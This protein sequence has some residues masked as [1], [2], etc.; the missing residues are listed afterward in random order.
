[1]YNQGHGAIFGTGE[2][3]TMTNSPANVHLNGQ[4]ELQITPIRNGTDW[5]SGRIQ[6]R[7]SA[8]SAPA[9][10]EMMVTST[11]KQPP[12]AD[13]TGY[14]T[15]FW[16]IGSGQWPEHGEIDILEDVDSSTGVSGSLHCGNLEQTNPDGTKGPCHETNGI[17]SGQRPCPDCQNGYHTYSMIIDR[18]TSEEQ[19]RWYLDG[20]QYFSINESRVGQA[21]WSEGVDSGFSIIFD[22][23]IGGGYPNIKCGCQTPTASTTSGASMSVKNVA[24]YTLKPTSS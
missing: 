5:T 10:G 22:V 21:A 20:R 3:E 15:G 6:T 23:A 2:I 17:G 14:W 13:P 8:F 12:A 1:M 11:L 19:I 24:V 4:G 9:G 16:V 18:R 7:S